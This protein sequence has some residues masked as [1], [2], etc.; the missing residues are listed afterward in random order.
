MPRGAFLFLLLLGSFLSFDEPNLHLNGQ[1]SQHNF[2]DVGWPA[3]GYISG[4]PLPVRNSLNEGLLVG[5]VREE[6][7][8]MLR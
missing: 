2:G 6:T 7:H 4:K 1:S 5:H 3:R 8:L